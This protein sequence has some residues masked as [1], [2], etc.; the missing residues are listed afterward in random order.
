MALAGGKTVKRKKR[1]Q[2]SNLESFIKKTLGG[3]GEGLKIETLANTIVNKF[4]DSHLFSDTALE[5]DNQEAKW[6]VGMQVLILSKSKDRWIRGFIKCLGT[7]GYVTVAYADRVKTVHPDSESLKCASSIVIES[8]SPRKVPRKR[9]I[10]EVKLEFDQTSAHNWSPCLNL[11]NGDR[12]HNWDIPEYQE[13]QFSEIMRVIEKN[14]VNNEATDQDGS[15]K[16]TV[17]TPRDDS[18]RSPKKVKSATCP[19]QMRDEIVNRLKKIREQIAIAA[20]SKNS[21]LASISVALEDVEKAKEVSRKNST[22]ELDDV[23]NPLVD[24][25]VP[26]Q[27]EIENSELT[28]LQNLNFSGSVN[29]LSNLDEE[30]HDTEEERLGKGVSAKNIKTSQETST[31]DPNWELLPGLDVKNEGISPTKFGVMSRQS[32]VAKVLVI[33]DSNSGKTSIIQRYVSETFSDKQT[34]TVGIDFATK[35]VQVSG[36][37]LQLIFWDIAGQERFIG[38]APTYYRNAVAAVIVFDATENLR[39]LD[40]TAKWKFEVDCKVF[41]PNEDPVPVVFLANKWDLIETGEKP[42]IISSDILDTYCRKQSFASW[43]PTSAKTGLNIQKGIDFLVS[44]IIENKHKQNTIVE[45][46]KGAVELTTRD[47]VIDQEGGCCG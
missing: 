1:V 19:Q 43:F 42:Q 33:G 45:P 20:K 44:M 39:K 40:N 10:E 4:Y 41:Y 22:T 16:L 21:S 29:V 36:E 47:S 37:K 12:L 23:Q 25:K 17:S 5:K 8:P 24:G 31:M 15:I 13:K 28:P 34:A 18:C 32:Y 3:S 9:S 26:R 38:L 2:L 11:A 35:Y 27:D 46:T 14:L 30:C 7:E 6:K